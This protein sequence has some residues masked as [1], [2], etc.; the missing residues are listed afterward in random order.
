MR[1]VRTASGAAV[2]IV[3]RHRDEVVGIE[4][5]GSAN[6]DADL[7]LLRSAA[8]ERLT[9]GQEAFDLSPGIRSARDRQWL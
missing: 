8:Q 1:R 4:H 9:L 7:A 5:I 3:E 6:A 2:Q